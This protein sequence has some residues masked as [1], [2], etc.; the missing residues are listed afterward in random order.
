MIEYKLLNGSKLIISDST[1][2]HLLAH[3]EISDELLETAIR[4][5]LSLPSTQ[6]ITRVDLYYIY[7]NW[8]ISGLIKVPKANLFAFRKGRPTPSAVIDYPGIPSSVLALVTKPIEKDMFKLIT[9]Y[10]AD[11][12][13]NAVPEP[14]TGHLDPN[15]EEGKKL[16][17]DYLAFW[18]LH[19]LAL[20]CTPIDGTPFE[21]TWEEVIQK[22]GDYYQKF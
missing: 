10:C 4:N 5:I 2:K 9:A 16:R 1:E 17:K 6:D 7:G 15:T 13:I 18:Q 12:F 3:P 22:Y 21:S 8:G 14:I 19:A 11:P 20:G